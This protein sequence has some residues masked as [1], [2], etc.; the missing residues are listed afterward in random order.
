MVLRVYNILSGESEADK[1]LYKD[2]SE[3]YGYVIL[4]DM[5]WD[6]TTLSSLYLVAIVF[7]KEIR[8]LR[9]LRRKHLGMLRGIRREATKIIQEKWGLPEGSTRFF[10]HYQP[11]Y[12]ALSEFHPIPN[13]LPLS[14][15]TTSMCTL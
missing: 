12:C 5:K 11:S 15:Q 6:L 1:I 7:S 14:V 2:P 10:I 3:E 8:C 13:N 9:D 4:P